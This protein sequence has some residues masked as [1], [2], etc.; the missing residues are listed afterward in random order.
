MAARRKVGRQPAGL[1]APFSLGCLIYLEWCSSNGDTS[2]SRQERQE[3]GPVEFRRSSSSFL[4]DLINLL[5]K[6]R[7]TKDSR[8][9][10]TLHFGSLCVL[11][12]HSFK[13]YFEI[14]GV[15]LN[16]TPGW[17]CRLINSHM[18]LYL[19]SLSF[20]SVYCWREFFFFRV[21]KNNQI[22][23][24]S[25]S[26]TAYCSEYFVI[27]GIPVCSKNLPRDEHVDHTSLSPFLLAIPQQRDKTM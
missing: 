21:H 4:A 14:P 17:Y 18:V 13:L 20:Q 11:C 19:L 23:N 26:H 1:Q 24:V 7:S 8:T 25:L 6:L 27:H 12:C 2:C 22:F 16:F 10:K 3:R 5:V 15:N 9:K